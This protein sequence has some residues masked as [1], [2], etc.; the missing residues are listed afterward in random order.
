VLPWSEQWLGRC[1]LP[2]GEIRRCRR[3]KSLCIAHEH[4]YRPLYKYAY[5]SMYIYWCIYAFTRWSV[6][7][8]CLCFSLSSFHLLSPV[9]LPELSTPACTV[10]PV[11]ILTART[12]RLWLRRQLTARPST[13]FS[14]VTFV[15][16]SP[17]S[18]RD[19]LVGDAC[20]NIAH[21]QT[22]SRICFARP[23]NPTPPQ[24]FPAQRIIN[25]R[26]DDELAMQG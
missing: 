2:E 5:I 17:G 24:P 1:H 7:S 12:T 19:A 18:R 21:T 11:P 20:T 8:F 6:A 15:A 13:K 23:F 25:P 3:Y 4:D 22:V 16:L 14:F 26:R 10:C 9:L